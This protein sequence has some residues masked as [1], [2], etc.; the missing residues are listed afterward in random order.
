[1]DNRIRAGDIEVCFSSRV[2]Q[3]T[4]REVVVETGVG[5]RSLLAD[6]VLVLT[7]SRPDLQLLGSTGKMVDWGLPS[8]L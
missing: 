3:I 4:P 8:S 1:M 5:T 6:Y 2:L 7:G